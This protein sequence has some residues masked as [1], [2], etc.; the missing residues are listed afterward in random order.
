M[1]LFLFLLSRPQRN[2]KKTTS[3]SKLIFFQTFFVKWIHGLHTA[4]M[5]I[6]DEKD[7]SA[8]VK[9]WVVSTKK[10]RK[11]RLFQEEETACWSSFFV[12]VRGPCKWYRFYCEWCRLATK[13]TKSTTAWNVKKGEF[14]KV[15]RIN[16][17]RVWL[18]TRSSTCLLICKQQ[19][20]LGKNLRTEN[21]TRSP[22]QDGIRTWFRNRDQHRF[23][24]ASHQEEIHDHWYSQGVLKQI[25]RRRLQG[26]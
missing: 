10:R 20:F 4:I 3:G 25:R 14:W 21:F 19:P 5:T 24:D 1:P 9:D 7:A 12:L 26:R 8:T 23:V 17:G 13:S 11:D 6:H 2:T 16:C 18:S 22:P 15:S